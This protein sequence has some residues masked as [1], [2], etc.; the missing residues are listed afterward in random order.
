MILSTFEENLLPKLLHSTPRELSSLYQEIQDDMLHIPLAPS[1]LREYQEILHFIDCVK[2]TRELEQVHIHHFI[3]S[4][5]RAR[6]LEQIC[7]KAKE[8]PHA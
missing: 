7:P 4:I 8:S 6:T 2:T 1:E 5:K 3:E